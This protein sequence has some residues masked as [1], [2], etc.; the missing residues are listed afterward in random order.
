MTSTPQPDRMVIPASGDL[1][2][3]VPLFVPKELTDQFPSVPGAPPTPSPQFTFRNSNGAMLS[4]SR[5][6]LRGRSGAPDTT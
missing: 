6:S 1:I 3:I 2:R 5:T 4:W